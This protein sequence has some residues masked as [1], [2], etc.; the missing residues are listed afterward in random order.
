MEE[1]EVPIDEVKEHIEHHAE[2]ASEG[3]IPKVALSTAILA[4][5]AAVSSLLAGSHA[6]DA[7]VDQ[8]KASDEWNHY[9]AKG[10]KAEV[11]GAHEEVLK[12][13]GR[14]PDP[15]LAQQL[16]RY[17]KEKEELKANAL[18]KEKGAAVNLEQHEI[19]ARAVTLFQIA[20]AIGAISVL[21]KRQVF[22]GASLVFGAVGVFFLAQGLISQWQHAEPKAAAQ[23]E[24]RESE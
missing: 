22:W 12:A 10:I 16:E 9:Q 3:W 19:F 7:M 4:A 17:G 11:V 5:F 24:L 18:E 21:T 13:I 20:I 23:S 2:H 15:A 14:T 6:N 8:I 1:P